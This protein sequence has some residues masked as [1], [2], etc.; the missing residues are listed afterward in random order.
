[1]SAVALTV[2]GEERLAYSVAAYDGHFQ[3]TFLMKS[4]KMASHLGKP[5]NMR[6]IEF[7]ASRGIS[8]LTKEKV[9]RFFQAI[10]V[11]NVREYLDSGCE[12]PAKSAAYL[13]N[14]SPT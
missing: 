6:L 11:E 2:F 14:S 9:E 8:Y 13:K 3:L 7:A 5:V 1:V 12:R 10:P 4:V